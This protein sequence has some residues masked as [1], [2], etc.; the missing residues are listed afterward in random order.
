ML[1]IGRD[2]APDGAVGEGFDEYLFYLLTQVAN[3]RSR[4]FAP[5]LEA[6]GLSIPEWRAL[7]VIN[8][9]DGCLMSELAEFTTV[10]RTTLTRTVDQLVK[11]DLVGRHAS[12]CDPASGHGR[13][14]SPRPYLFRERDRCSEKLQHPCSEWLI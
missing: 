14:D 12:T 10:D 1:D 6:I 13:P 2:D 5:T 11:R 7:S 3:R 9:L 8:R 4:D